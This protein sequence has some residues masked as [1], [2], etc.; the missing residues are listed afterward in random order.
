MWSGFCIPIKLE[1]DP[2]TLDINFESNLQN[3]M[4]SR[5]IAVYYDIVV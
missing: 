3:H 1:G 5:P 2:L 4:Q